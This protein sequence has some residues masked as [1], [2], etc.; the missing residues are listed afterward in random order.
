MKI[1]SISVL[2][3]IIAHVKRLI[4]NFPPRRSLRSRQDALYNTYLQRFSER[5]E[6]AGNAVD[7]SGVVQ[8]RQPGYFLRRHL[9]PPRQPAGRI[10]CAT[11]SFRSKIFA[12]R[13]AGSSIRCWPRLDFEGAGIGRPDS[14]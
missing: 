13:L 4:V 1:F 10:F 2:L 8:A 11:I 7:L 12:D 14:R 5:L 6:R 9:Q 3:Q